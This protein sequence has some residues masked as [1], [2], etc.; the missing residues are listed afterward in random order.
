MSNKKSSLIGTIMIIII[1]IILSAIP[2]TILEIKF[3]IDIGVVGVM[4]L[5]LI[6]AGICFI[7]NGFIYVYREG[8]KGNQ[9]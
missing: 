6:I 2:A 9:Q 7:I 8:K 4:I 1:S 3:G 5:Y